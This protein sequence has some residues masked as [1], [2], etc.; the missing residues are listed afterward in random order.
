[1][2]ACS[3][4][5]PNIVF[6]LVD[7]LGWMDT[8]IYGSNYYQTPHIDQLALEGTR[9]TQ[10]YSS[11]PVCSPTRASIMTGKHPAR[12]KITNWIGGEANGKL[13]QA[14]YN[15][16]LPLEEVTIGDTFEQAGYRT[17]Y[18]GKWHLGTDEFLPHNQGFET[19]TATNDAGQPGS[20]FAPYTSDTFPISNVPDLENDPDSTYLTDRLTDIAIN[21]IESH[22][23]QPFFLV[24]SYYS[25]HTP[26]QAKPDL[27]KR[28]VSSGEST[29]YV[30]ESFGGLTRITQN[31]ATYAAMIASV[32]ESVGRI[33]RTLEA[34]GIDKNTIVVFTSDNGGLS[35]LSEGRHWAPTSNLP[36][37][38]GKGWLYEGGIRIPLIIKGAQEGG[39]LN[40]ILG[41]TNDLLP[42]IAGLAQITPPKQID[43][44]NLFKT[45]DSDRA[46]YWHFPHYHGS[47]NRPSG[48]IRSGRYKLIE[49]FETNSVEL[50]DLASDIGETTDI[51]EFEPTIAQNLMQNLRIWRD[52]IDANM[53]RLNPDFV[54]QSNDN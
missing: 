32:D 33:M 12:L 48:A 4:N 28:F 6:I 40:D 39:T 9:F 38:S 26:L 50:Y 52:S 13:L 47:A 44:V 1:M 51:S 42:T 29:E 8:G 36:L 19:V 23:Q 49:W 15:Y 43:G 7:D 46:L 54:D 17:S 37:R 5:Q 41:T 53:P 27:I 21:F 34:S 25:V 2:T 30:E 20:F 31:H 45:A 24:L 11:S 22:D 18:V 3:T 14:E 10:F 35:T 16:A